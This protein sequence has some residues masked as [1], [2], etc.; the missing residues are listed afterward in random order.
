MKN[1]L[2]THL[3]THLLTRFATRSPLDLETLHLPPYLSLPFKI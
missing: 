3:L 1:R 2:L